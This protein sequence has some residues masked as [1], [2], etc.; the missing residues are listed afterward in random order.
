MSRATGRQSANFGGDF[1]S[2]AADGDVAV[3]EVAF[4]DVDAFSSLV[5]SDVFSLWAFG[6][7]AALLPP[8]VVGV[9][10]PPVAAVAGEIRGS[11]DAAA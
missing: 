6:P 1:S 8:C 4:V 2:V 3:G 5:F 11:S 9:A 10:N 7:R